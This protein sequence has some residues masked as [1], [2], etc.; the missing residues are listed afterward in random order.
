MDL[1]GW[2]C[3]SVTF[4]PIGS[5]APYT[6]LSRAEQQTSMATAN[7]APPDASAMAKQHLNVVVLG[8][9]ASGA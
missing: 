5:R 4:G 2:E 8:A 6:R 7:G 1:H 9:K 3:D